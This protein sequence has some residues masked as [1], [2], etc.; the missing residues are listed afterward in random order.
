MKV[1]SES[2]QE[3]P[4]PLEAGQ[5]QKYMVWGSTWTLSSSRACYMLVTCPEDPPCLP[6]LSVAT[7]PSN[8]GLSRWRLPLP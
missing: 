1:K 4:C 6:G 3:E 2:A 8:L 7:S 5:S